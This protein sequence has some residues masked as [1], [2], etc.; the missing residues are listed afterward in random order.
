MRVEEVERGWRRW[1]GGEG[2]GGG[3]G[4][5]EGGGGGQGVRVEERER[6]EV[7]WWEEAGEIGA[8]RRSYGGSGERKASR[9]CGG[10]RRWKAKMV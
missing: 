5:G 6:G 1:T 8:R 2:G 10:G 9:K 3:E 7:T 4:L